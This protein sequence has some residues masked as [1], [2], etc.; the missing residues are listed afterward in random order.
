MVK[1]V[2][3][4][5]RAGVSVATVSRVLNQPN[6]VDPA[7]R[8][9]VQEIIRDTGYRPNVLA[10]GLVRKSSKTIG[11]VINQFSSSY[12]GRML[13][14]AQTVLAEVGFKLIAESSGETAEGEQAALSSL[15]D[16][17]CEGIVLH[18]DKLS[19]AQVAELLAAHPNLVLMNRP[20][21]KDQNRA[22]YIDN[23][24]IGALAAAYLLKMGHRDIAVV[25]GPMAYFESRHR[26]E[27]FCTTLAAQN[28]TLPKA[29]ILNGL[30]N[31]TSGYAAMEKIR[32]RLPDVTAVFFMN[33]E[34]AA[35]AIDMCLDTGI[36]VPG[37]V[38]IL[39][40]DD[41]D[42]ARFMHPKL[43]TLRQP[44]EALG[45]AAGALAH[46]IATGEDGAELPRVLEAEIKERAS[47]RR[48]S[49]RR[50]L[51]G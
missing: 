24:Q 36:A 41:L 44:L 28:I 42:V 37:D 8:K 51:K 2:D 21:A 10:Q 4:A 23:R 30:F 25:T 29:N 39:G 46:A 7:K 27:G 26:L 20:A 50:A 45:E 17:Q 6:L 31:A 22:V 43:T 32:A 18:A 1:M 38:S 15:I 34:M 48:I 13:D 49:P 12:Y 19:D 47:V 11:V 40:C 9:A 35:G 33:D 3:I 14:G 16:R 5:Q